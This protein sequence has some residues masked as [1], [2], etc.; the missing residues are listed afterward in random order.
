VIPF[1]TS[2]VRVVTD[3][4]LKKH[5]KNEGKVVRFMPDLKVDENKE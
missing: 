5:A 1:Y 4:R 3:D 2:H